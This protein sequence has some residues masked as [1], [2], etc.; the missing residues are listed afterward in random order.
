M[1]T[2]VSVIILNWNGEKLLKRFLP[3]VVRFLPE[4]AQL[5]VADNGSADG[6]IAYINKEYPQIR[7]IAF[8]KNYGF[9]EGYNK[10]INLVD[11]PYCVLLNS[12]VEV[13]NDWVTPLLDYM[14]A[15]PEVGAAQPKILSADNPDK[16]EYAGACGGFL[17]RHG[18][19]YCRGRIFDTVERDAGQYDSPINVFWASGAA[20]MVRTEIYKRAGGLDKEFFA[21]M[22]EIDLCWRIKLL[23]YDIAVV[24]QSQ[25]YHLGGGSLPAENPKKTYLNF[26]NNLLMLHKNSP[27]S[28]RRSRLFVRRL[29]DTVAWL[30]F[31]LALDFKNASAIIGAHRDF[32][33]M[34][35]FYNNHPQEDILKM[36]PNKP[37]S[38]LWQ[39]FVKRKKNF[40]RL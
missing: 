27:D 39:Y 1:N 36:S 9:A 3:S 8:E 25:V 16:F 31:L 12:D 35:K 11:T 33:K 23:G 32:A 22:E 15:H 5:V 10:A 18:Y 30:R 14:E 17:D 34:R 13:K 2:K 24:P 37:I 40:N 38:I 26:R 29:L 7:I 19:P 4:S 28:V 21:H 20:L 6:S